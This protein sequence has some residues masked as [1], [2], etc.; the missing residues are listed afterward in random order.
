MQ[1]TLGAVYLLCGFNCFLL[2]IIH[3]ANCR[4]RDLGS[5]FKACVEIA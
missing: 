2:G 1:V 4:I 5:L 3:V